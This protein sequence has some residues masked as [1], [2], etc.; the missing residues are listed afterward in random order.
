MFL[1]IVISFWSMRFSDDKGQGQANTLSK[2]RLQVKPFTQMLSLLV[3]CC[4]GL[5]GFVSTFYLDQIQPG[6]AMQLSP[7]S[8]T[9]SFA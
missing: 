8:G 3:F 2:Q 7:G 9:L 6:N 5:L 1:R 4:F